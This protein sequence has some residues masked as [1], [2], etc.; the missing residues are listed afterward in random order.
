MIDERRPLERTA[1]EARSKEGSPLA[2]TLRWNRVS[3]AWFTERHLS[4]WRRVDEEPPAIS[5]A[6]P[7]PIALHFAPLR[8]L[9]QRIAQVSTPTENP[10]ATGKYHGSSRHITTPS[11]P[12]N[13]SQRRLEHVDR[14]N[15]H[16]NTLPI[17]LSGYSNGLGLLQ[18]QTRAI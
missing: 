17:K 16:Y 7:A 11:L 14:D 3:V 9:A 12:T 5:Q 10:S 18:V 15:V 6:L 2:P 13:I 4:T 1:H 8:A